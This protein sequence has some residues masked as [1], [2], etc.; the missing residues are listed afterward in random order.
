MKVFTI[1]AALLT[2]VALAVNA[3][4]HFNLASAFD[5]NP[6]SLGSQ[7]T[8]FRVQAVLDLLAAVLILVRPRPW[9][10]FVAAVVA[11]GGLALIVITVTVPLDLTAIGLPYLYEPS[12]YED[13]VVSAV[14]QGLAVVGA[15]FVVLGSR[16]ST[17][18][19]RKG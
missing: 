19:T 14:A 5:G 3:F 6:G 10:A 13:K 11:G 9:T 15:L 4:I 17:S 18:Q 1:G 16:V 12:W 8:L 2:A 7:G